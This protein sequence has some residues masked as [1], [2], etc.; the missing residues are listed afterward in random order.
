M[1]RVKKK[2]KITKLL[3]EEKCQSK[4]FS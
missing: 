2:V 1:E 4:C 3:F